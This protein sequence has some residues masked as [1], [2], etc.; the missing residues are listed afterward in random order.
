MFII[1]LE[2][3]GRKFR[4]NIIRIS[5]WFRLLH[6]FLQPIFLYTGRIYADVMG[7]LILLDLKDIF[8]TI[9]DI[10]NPA[11]QIVVLPIDML[12]EITIQANKS[13]SIEDVFAGTALLI[14]LFYVNIK[15]GTWNPI[16]MIIDIIVTGLISIRIILQLFSINTNN[17]GKKEE[18]IEEK[19]VYDSRP[20]KRR[21]TRI[22]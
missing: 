7:Y 22:K 8:I 14:I 21:S 16:T 10:I 5:M 18:N 6:Q 3:C 20:Q 13:S 15:W 17:G 4:I 9:V 19:E 11:I 12:S 2:H 1:G